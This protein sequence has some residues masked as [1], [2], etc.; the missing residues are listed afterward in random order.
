VLVAELESAVE[1]VSALDPSEVEGT[2]AAELSVRLHR[3]IDRLRAVQLGLLGR[4]ESDAA[5]VGTGARSLTSWV[6]R[7][8]DVAYREAQRW[9]RSARVWRDSLA[10]TGAAARSGLVPTAKGELIAAVASTPERLAALVEPLPADD[11]EDPAAS[12]PGAPRGTRF[13]GERFLLELAQG[14]HVRDFAQLTRRFA[15]VVDP[16]ADERGYRAA[17]AR[18]FFDLAKTSGGYHLSGFLTHDNGQAVKTA[19][20]AVTGIPASGDTRTP[21]RRRAGALTDLATLVL[22]QGLTGKVG[23]VRPHLSVHVTYTELDHVLH[24]AGACSGAGGHRPSD[25]RAPVTPE[26]LAS[27]VT[28][29]PA[30]WEDGTGPIPDAVLRRLAADC[31]IS[32]VVFGPGSEVLD[33]GRSRRTFAGH[34]RRAVV[35]RDR[36]CV[37]EGCGA[38][39]FMGQVHHAKVR[40]ADGGTTRVAD[41]A[42]VC[43]FHNRWLEEARVP[44]RF[45][46]DDSGV[47]RWQTGTPGTYR[48]DGTG[49]FPQDAAD[50]RADESVARDGPGN[51]PRLDS[52]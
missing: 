35:A 17:T 19:L 15:H 23:T 50:S 20:R 24:R 44:M 40:W 26:R 33:V 1:R 6:A 22:D 47:G 29:P 51:A 18:E 42:L 39:A 41:G 8:H 37:V 21:S 32:R 25:P 13:T 38:P 48:S 9:V 30:E 16:E 49:H 12:G 36:A 2:T 45:V 10:A 5:W 3:G 46:R 11:D 14:H 28:A 27:L 31:E 52:S 43:G 4:V 7:C 34:L